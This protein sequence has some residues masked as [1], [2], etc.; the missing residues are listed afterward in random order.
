MKKVH[1]QKKKKKKLTP[2][3]YALLP[4]I[5]IWNDY[6]HAIINEHFFI[7]FFSGQ[8]LIEWFSLSALYFY[9]FLSHI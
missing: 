9:F 6:V 2:V 4:F 5:Y 1:C 8:I 3:Q 7:L